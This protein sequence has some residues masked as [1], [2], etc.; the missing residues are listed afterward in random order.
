MSFDLGVFRPKK[1]LDAATAVA[2]YKALTTK[3]GSATAVLAPTKA[4]AAFYEALTSTYPEIDDA[5]DESPFA[6]PSS[7]GHTPWS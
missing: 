7:V 1:P 3:G 4:L 6:W 2:V 5:P